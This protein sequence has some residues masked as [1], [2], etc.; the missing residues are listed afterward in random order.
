M[1]GKWTTVF[2]KVPVDPTLPV[3]REERGS[4]DQQTTLILVLGLAIT[5]I[6]YKN[7]DLGCLASSVG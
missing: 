7:I 1:V 5:F 4:Q 3:S 6:I 2:Q